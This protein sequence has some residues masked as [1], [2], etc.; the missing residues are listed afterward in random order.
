MAHPNRYRAGVSLSGY[1]DPATPLCQPWVRHCS[2]GQASTG[3]F[4]AVGVSHEW[5]DQV[6][7]QRPGDPCRHAA[8]AAKPIGRCPIS[9]ASFGSGPPARHVP[10]GPLADPPQLTHDDP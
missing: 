6:P 8:R 3:R 9:M 5:P 2:T 1:N 4:R 7:G 10:S